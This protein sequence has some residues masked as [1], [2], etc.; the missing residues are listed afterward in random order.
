MARQLSWQTL[1]GCVRDG[2]EA[3]GWAF[4]DLEGGLLGIWHRVLPQLHLLLP[5]HL[6]NV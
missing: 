4:R 5:G 2:Q 6:F 3:D 1:A